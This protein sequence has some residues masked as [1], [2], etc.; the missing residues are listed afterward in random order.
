MA[1]TPNWS[2]L[3]KVLVLCCNS[4]DTTANGKP[5]VTEVNW[6]KDIWMGSISPKLKLFMWTILQNALPLG[7][8]LKRRSLLA[9]TKCPRCD[10]EETAMHLFFECDFAKKVW[11]LIPLKN[12]VHLAAEE[13]FQGAIN[14]FRRVSCLPPAGISEDILPWICWVIWTSRNNLIFENRRLSPEETA[15][16]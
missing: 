4:E 12:A 5:A 3:H 13:T 14:I 1:T 6:V 15:T 7:E 2:L 9:N 16:K 8:N 11:E 10:E